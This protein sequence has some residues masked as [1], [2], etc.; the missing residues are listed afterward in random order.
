ML[1]LKITQELPMVKGPVFVEADE[2]IIVALTLVG[3]GLDG[4]LDFAE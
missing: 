4:E 1:H 2:H 3:L